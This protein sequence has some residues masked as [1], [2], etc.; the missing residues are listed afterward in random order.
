MGEREQDGGGG[1]RAGWQ[2]E[3]EWWRKGEGRKGRVGWWKEKVSRLR[4]NG[5]RGM[6]KGKKD[7]PG[8]VMVSDTLCPAVH[9]LGT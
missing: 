5:E 2:S 8:P 6:G 1:E 9:I 3:R 4:E 7:G